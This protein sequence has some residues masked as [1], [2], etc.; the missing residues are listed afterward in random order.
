MDPRLEQALRC[1][2]RQFFGRGAVGIGAAALA[3]LVAPRGRIVA[4]TPSGGSLGALHF[5][6]RAQRVLY[7]FQ[8][9]GPAQMELF[10][11]KPRLRELHGEDLPASVRGTQRLTGFTAGQGTYPI[12]ASPFEFSRQGHSG[13]WVS[14]LLPHLAGVVDDLAIVKSVHTEAINHDPAVTYLLTGSQQ[15]G[16]PSVGAWLSYGRRQHRAWNCLEPEGSYAW[17]ERADCHLQGSPEERARQA[18]LARTTWRRRL[19]GLHALV[20]LFLGFRWTQPGQGDVRTDRVA[21]D[22]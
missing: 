16:R 11:Y 3:S 15:A 13:A 9:G 1:T 19:R 7:I 21:A 8:A 12:V 22:G 2:R 10:D 5:A 14:E 6:P 18:C 4:A 17:P 20:Q